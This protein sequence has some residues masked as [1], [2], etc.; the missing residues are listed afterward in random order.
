VR[1]G[2]IEAVATPLRRSRT[3]RVWSLEVSDAA[4]RLVGSARCTVAAME[5]ESAA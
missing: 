3:A 1:D 4:D 2:W 5:T